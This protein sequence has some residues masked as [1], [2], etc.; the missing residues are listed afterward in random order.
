MEQVGYDTGQ[1]VKVVLALIMSAFLVATVFPVI[2]YIA[3]SYDPITLCAL[4]F[5]FSVIIFA[6]VYFVKNRLLPPLKQ[7]IL[8]AFSSIFLAGFFLGWF[9]ALRSANSQITSIIY[10][11]LPLMTILIQILLTRGKGVS[12]MLF[13][14][15]LLG[16]VNGQF[17]VD[18]GTYAVNLLSVGSGEF[19]FF[20]ACLS[21]AIY[22][23][24]S[25]INFKMDALGRTFWSIVFATAILVIAS[26]FFGDINSLKSAKSMEVYLLTL[27]LAINT[28]VTFYLMQFAVS[29]TGGPRASLNVFLVPVFVVLM[30][31]SLRG[32][33]GLDMIKFV[34]MS[35]A[36]LIVVL[37]NTPQLSLS[38]LFVRSSD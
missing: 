30:E 34:S 11:T 19:I 8:A 27:Y 21:M 35:I 3:G 23:I 33:Y 16:L 13:G 22:L 7:L 31:M 12:W 14:L 6:P 17:L 38:R 29:V 24:A 18:R 37:A 4:R 15:C 1:S 5:L 26:I 32:N 10:L 9:V 25:H 2:E 36:F 28:F 20:L